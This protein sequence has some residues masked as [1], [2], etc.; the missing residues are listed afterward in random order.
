MGPLVVQA[1]F[2]PWPSGRWQEVTVGELLS[3]GHCRTTGK[4]AKKD[5]PTK[6]TEEQPELR[7]E[8]PK[9]K[10]ARRKGW[11]IA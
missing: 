4:W 10:V 3:S 1:A 2:Q 9:E 7:E 6:E 8:H 5:T 11:S